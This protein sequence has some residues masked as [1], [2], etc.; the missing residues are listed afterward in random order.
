MLHNP[1]RNGVSVNFLVG[2]V[3]HSLAP[4]EWQELPSTSVQEVV[5]DGGGD[6]GDRRLLVRS[7]VFVFHVSAQRG[8]ELLKQ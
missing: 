5:F 1:Q 7:G 8:W 6:F 3:V 2:D 4:G